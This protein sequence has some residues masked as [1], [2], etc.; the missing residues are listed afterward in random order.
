[1][2]DQPWYMQDEQWVV[3][4]GELGVAD[5]ATTGEV[6]VDAKGRTLLWLDE[7]YDM[8]GPLDLR[9]LERFGQTDFA[10]CTVMTRRFWEKNHEALRQEAAFARH[11]YE[12]RVREE[13]A[14]YRQRQQSAP[15]NPAAAHSERQHRKTLD[16]PAEGTLDVVQIKSA[17]RRLAQRAHPDQGGDHEEFVKI[18]EARDALLAWDS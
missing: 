18:T 8:V 7:P 2:T 14:R 15:H 10:N 17:F 5:R 6:E 4:N 11:A 1:M 16:L 13:F 3:W 9:E 12:Q